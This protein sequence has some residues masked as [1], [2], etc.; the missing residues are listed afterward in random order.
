[1][2]YHNFTAI[3]WVASSFL[4][5]GQD[6]NPWAGV[7]LFL[8]CFTL[9]G[10]SFLCVLSLGGGT[11]PWAVYLNPGRG[12]CSFG[13]IDQPWGGGTLLGWLSLSLWENFLS[14]TVSQPCW[15]GGF[16]WVLSF[17][18]LRRTSSLGDY[19]SAGGGLSCGCSPS[20]LCW[21]RGFSL[22]AYQPCSGESLR[23]LLHLSPGFGAVS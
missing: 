8:G 3:L 19:L 14:G 22:L 11:I 17:S 10:G 15:R 6:F 21:G 13:T 20:Q 2:W 1:M 16:P 12:N 23:W 7:I 18:P 9:Q 4:Q 5:Q